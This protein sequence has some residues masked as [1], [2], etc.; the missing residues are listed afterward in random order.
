MH[1]RNA[2]WLIKNTIAE[3]SEPVNHNPRRNRSSAAGDRLTI[4][5][6]F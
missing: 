2:V 4:I 1:V 5:C 3:I 6:S